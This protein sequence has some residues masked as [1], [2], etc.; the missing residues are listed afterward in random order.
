MNIKDKIDDILKSLKI[1][2]PSYLNLDLYK[3]FTSVINIQLK[4]K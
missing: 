4:N 3:I 1:E 2:L